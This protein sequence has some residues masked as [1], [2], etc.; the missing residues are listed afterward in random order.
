ML[1]LCLVVL[2]LDSESS[3]IAP[4]WNRPQRIYWGAYILHWIA[5]DSF[6]LCLSQQLPL[7]VLVSNTLPICFW[8]ESIQLMS[9]SCEEMKWGRLFCSAF[10]GWHWLSTGITVLDEDGNALGKSKKAGFYALTQVSISRVCTSFACLSVPPIILGALL[11]PKAIQ[12]RPA[13]HL[14]ITLGKPSSHSC[15]CNFRSDCWY[16]VFLS[17]SGNCSLPPGKSPKFEPLTVQWC[18]VSPKKLEPEFHN[19]KD[20]N[21]KPIEKVIYNRGLW[22]NRVRNAAVIFYQFQ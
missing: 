6:S 21:G 3:W 12:S 17:S 18:E 20:R 5:L 9:F 22:E 10:F 13:L 19:L 16:H 11:R 15:W 2:L 14:P 1:W 4:R 8:I 7:L